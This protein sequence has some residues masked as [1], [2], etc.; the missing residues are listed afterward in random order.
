MFITILFP[1]MLVFVMFLNVTG[2]KLAVRP[3]VIRDRHRVQ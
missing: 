2:R 3:V 1:L